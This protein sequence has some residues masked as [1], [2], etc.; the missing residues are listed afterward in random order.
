MSYAEQIR[1]EPSAYK[2]RSLIADGIEENKAIADNAKETAI[3]AD[4]NA[5]EAKEQVEINT[6]QWADYK[7]TMDS[8]EAIRKANEEIRKSNE[9]GRIT[10]EDTRE[11]A[12][13]TRQNNET[14]RIDNEQARE[15]AFDGME[16]VDANLEL[17][18]AR[19]TFSTLS[20]R[21]DNSEGEN[22]GT[23]ELISISHNFDSYPNVRCICTNYGAGV[24][25]AGNVPAGGT[26]SYMV[27]ARVCYLDTNSIKIYV[28]KHYTVRSPI[29][30]KIDD[31]KYIIASNDAAETKSILINLTEVA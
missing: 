3:N 15:T 14:K 20:D 22:L 7:H 29:V 23:E 16:H 17:S 19:G 18:T 13:I 6:T 21:L 1:V 4:K 31:K 12:E 28:P 25:E 10:S 11:Q 5:T 26:E 27:N 2:M 24:G 9:D 30:E 8:A